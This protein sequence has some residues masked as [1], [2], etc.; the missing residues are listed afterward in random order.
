VVVEL[1]RPALIGKVIAI[2][3]A[4]NGFGH[5]L[6]FIE[7]DERIDLRHLRCEFG[8]VALRHA[9]GNNQPAQPPLSFPPS[10]LEDGVD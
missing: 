5:T 1:Q 9:A 10:D 4:K 7:P 2:E 8:G 6:E 3:R